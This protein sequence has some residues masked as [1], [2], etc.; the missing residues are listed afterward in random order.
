L[1]I[2]PNFKSVLPWDFVVLFSYAVL[3]AIYTYVQLKPDIASRGIRIPMIGTIGKKEMNDE[4]LQLMKDKSERAA[5]IIAPIALILAILIHTVT[6]WV[7]AT[8]LSRPWWFGGA[9][10]PTFIASAIA[11]GPA[12][13][14]LASLYTLRYKESLAAAYSMLAKISVIGAV[15]L[16][17]IYYNDFMV[18]GWWEGGSEYETVNVLFS[19]YLG[20]HILEIA[21]ILVAIVL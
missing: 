4:E 11:S 5:R 13:V 9:L 19:D 3:A 16:L 7:L 21:G 14:I 2:H 20:L 6:A 17:F 8:Q 12:V 10:A 15:V 1:F 18:R